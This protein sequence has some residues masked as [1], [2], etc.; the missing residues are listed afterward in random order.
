M[1]D[2]HETAASIYREHSGRVLATLIRHLGDFDRAED[3]LQ[4][5][6]AR[7]LELWP[8]QG[9]PDNPAG[10]LVV[11]AKHRA[12]DGLRRE[13]RFAAK[14]EEIRHGMRTDVPPE[15][16]EDA[17]AFGDDRLRLIF[18]ACHPA[19][20]MEARVALTLRTLGGLGTGEIARAFLVPER[21]MAQR[22][23]RAKKKIRLAG[24]PY[25]VPDS[26][27]LPER[28]DGVLA[29]LYLIYNEG[30][31]ASE[32]ENLVRE[33]LAAEAIRL[34]RLVVTLL[35]EEPEALGLTALMLLHDSRR[36]ARVDREGELVTLEE[37]DR[38]LW[39]RAAIV[40]GL[41]LL[42]RAMRL[43]RPGPYQI[44]AAVAALHARAPSAES[45]DW[46]QI[47]R[48]YGALRSVTSSPVV[49]LNE[50]AALGMA[51]GPERGLAKIAAIEREGSL[52]DYHLLHAAKA[53]FLRRAGRLDEAI[54]AYD[55]ALSL[56]KNARERS[57]L[58][59]RRREIGRAIGRPH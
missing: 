31:T 35:P 30:Y 41:A 9:V 26:N 56:A 23:V 42:D 32:G 20:A 15:L 45:T 3:A 52:P 17:D 2:V 25:V 4:D 8:K 6:V 22:L 36:V 51:E 34:A 49:A 48:L 27:H 57:Y 5:A 38:C 44:Q 59:R 12:I 11:T 33:E 50:A 37:Q 54:D 29:V 39:D 7:A 55:R 43:G 24:I 40:E 46:P 13:N 10:W 19:L 16:P 58:E 28:L 53:D 1:S 14:R 47:A 18:T 21:T